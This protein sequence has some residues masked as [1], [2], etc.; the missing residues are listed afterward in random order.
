MDLS[1]HDGDIDLQDAS[2]DMFEQFRIKD[3][4]QDEAE[5]TR[6]EAFSKMDSD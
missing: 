3:K 4:Y 2:K 6:K 5:M 1:R